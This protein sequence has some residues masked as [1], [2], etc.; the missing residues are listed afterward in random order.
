MSACIPT[1]TKIG[2][3][4]VAWL[5]RNTLRNCWPVAAAIA[6]MVLTVFLG[7]ENRAQSGLVRMASASASQ[8]N[9]QPVIAASQVRVEREQGYVTLS[10]MASNLTQKPL[11]NVEAMVEFFDKSGGLV[12]SESALIDL[13]ALRGGEESPFTVQAKD[14][15]GIAAYR[16]RFRELLGASIP[17]ADR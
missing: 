6:A 1:G 15:A 3:S 7:S 12:K 11:K 8:A 9:Q 5:N 4:H 13:S 17:S 14:A 16:I 2:G 10:G